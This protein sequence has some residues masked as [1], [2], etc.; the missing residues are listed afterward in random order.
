MYQ[1]YSVFTNLNLITFKMLRVD[2]EKPLYICKLITEY[3]ILNSSVDYAYK[4]IIDVF[5]KTFIESANC[6]LT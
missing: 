1:Y 6:L 5:N 4:H 2:I 3:H